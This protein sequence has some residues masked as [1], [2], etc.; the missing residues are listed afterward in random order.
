MSESILAPIICALLLGGESEVRHPYQSGYDMTRIQVDCETD[1]HVV[2][3]GLDKRSSMDSL[4]QALFAAHV[5]G[6][7]PMVIIIDTDGKQG[8]YEYQIKTVSQ[9][10]GVEY[11]IYSKDFL[12]RWQ[13]TQYLRSYKP[14][15]DAGS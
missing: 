15:Q 3:I 7:K 9:A 11:E 12:I 14:A 4:H 1:T 8:P 2:E 6:L 5:T 10:A 13:M